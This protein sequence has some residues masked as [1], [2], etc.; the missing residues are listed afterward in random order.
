MILIE[1]DKSTVKKRGNSLFLFLDKKEVGKQKYALSALPELYHEGG[2][3]YQVPIR[4]FNEVLSALDEWDLIIHG[5]IPSEIETIIDTKNRVRSKSTEPRGYSFKTEPFQHQVDS[6]VYAQDNDKFLLGDEQGL[7]KTKQAIDIAVHRKDGFKH[8]LIICCV[9]GLKWNWANEVRTHSYEDSHIIGSR[10]NRNGN[11]IVD[12]VAKRVEDLLQPHDEFFLI[13]NIE[14]FRDAVFLEAV[15]EMCRNGDIGMVVIDE[16]HKCKNPNSQ[17]GSAILQLDSYYKLALTGTPMLSSP[18]DLFTILAWLDVEKHSFSSYKAY[19]CVMVGYS[20]I[21]GYKHLDELN[22]TIQS[23]MLRRLKDDVLNLPPKIHATEYV[24]MSSGQTKLYREVL[25]KIKKDID[26]VRVSASPLAE[27][28]RLRQ[29]TGNPDILTTTKVVNAKFERAMELIENAVF[30]GDK[31]LVFSNWT[32][33]IHPFHEF[34]SKTY[35]SSIVTGQVSD[36]QSQIDSFMNDDKVKVICG[37]TSALGTGYTLTEASTVIFLDS[38]WTQG[39][40]D[41]AEDRAHRIGAV[42]TVTVITLVCKNTI[43]ERVE[44]IVFGK[45]NMS[46]HIID[47]EGT[48]TG[49]AVTV[50][51]FLLS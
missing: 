1:I 46:K 19:Y 21:T 12:G 48:I 4:L 15:S 28:I 16:I 38:P 7:G 11:T 8:C 23:C 20:T 13:T 10:T 30:N 31:V 40:K 29:V 47:S 26:L 25:S 33:V 36:S 22:E 39:E 32:Q 14:T 44:E 18:I 43:D 3:C 35:K 24:D 45:G 17:I 27:L 50:L 9:S 49:D 37:T 34:V 42:D 41:Q 5:D 51:D 6:F 2:L